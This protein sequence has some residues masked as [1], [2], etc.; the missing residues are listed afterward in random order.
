M[1]FEIS[2]QYRASLANIKK[3]EEA[4]EEMIKTREEKEL[5]RW[6]IFSEKAIELA[7]MSPGLWNYRKY[8]III[9][10]TKLLLGW[11]IST[12]TKETNNFCC[13]IFE[14]EKE[15]STCKEIVELEFLLSRKGVLSDL[16]RLSVTFVCNKTPEIEERLEQFFQ[17]ILEKLISKKEA[18]LKA[19]LRNEG[20]LIDE[21]LG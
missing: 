21:S 17:E 16:S 10:G 20:L 6:A 5:K 12:V 19:F 7:S 9:V 13:L 18:Y 14:R 15:G 8:E 4:A 1:K 2:R 3:I 11:K